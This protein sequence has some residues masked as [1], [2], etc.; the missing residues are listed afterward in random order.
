MTP[1]EVRDQLEQ[2][3][4]G[5]VVTRYLGKVQDVGVRLWLEPRRDA[6][7]RT[8]LGDLLIRSPGGGYS[9]CAA[10]RHRVRCRTARD[11]PR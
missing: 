10:S 2:H 9:R 7:Y 8:Q 5:K 6:L 3:L 11:H 4:N 1:A